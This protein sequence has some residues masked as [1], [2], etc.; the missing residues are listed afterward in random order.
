MLVPLTLAPPRARHLAHAY[1]SAGELETLG[2]VVRI[3][4][5]MFQKM[6]ITKFK[7]KRKQHV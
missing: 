1:R 7:K 4:Y 2:A 6:K 3:D 5:Y